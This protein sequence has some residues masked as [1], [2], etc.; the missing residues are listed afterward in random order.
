MFELVLNT[1]FI[2]NANQLIGF[3]LI[4]I[5]T[6]IFFSKRTIEIW[7]LGLIIPVIHAKKIYAKYDKICTFEKN[8][9][10]NYH[11][12][13][14]SW[15]EWSEVFS[16]IQQ[17]HAI[18]CPG[19]YRLIFQSLYHS[20]LLLLKREI[21]E[22]ID[23]RNFRKLFMNKFTAYFWHFGTPFPNGKNETKCRAQEAYWSV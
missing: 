3:Y 7:I 9:H 18:T 11:C 5:F 21:D 8:P 1:P 22:I 10:K 16:I 17:E 20:S 15:V 14:K 4:R 6:E 23:F 13:K 19:L 12:E 2:W